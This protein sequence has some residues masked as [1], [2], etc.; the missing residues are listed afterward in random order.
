MYIFL[1]SFLFFLPDDCFCHCISSIISFLVGDT[2][3]SFFSSST[4]GFDAVSRIEICVSGSD[5]II[6]SFLIDSFCRKVTFFGALRLI[7]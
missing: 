3:S 5:L 7:L 2:S 1:G 6:S 4:D